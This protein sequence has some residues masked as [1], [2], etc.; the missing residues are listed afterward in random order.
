MGLTLPVRAGF[1]PVTWG[2]GRACAL[3][4]LVPDL[5]I[6]PGTKGARYLSQQADSQTHFRRDSILLPV[7]LGIT[8]AGAMAMGATTIGHQQV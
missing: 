1:T 2:W 5:D 4:V 3:V 7:L 6:L 8:L